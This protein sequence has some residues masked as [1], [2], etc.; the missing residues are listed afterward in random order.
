MLQSHSSIPTCTDDDAV[1][2][3]D[4]DGFDM[5]F[6]RGDLGKASEESCSV[7]DSS[8][9]AA[10]DTDMRRGTACIPNVAMKW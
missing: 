6:T 5:D 3:V 7:E 2:Q 4:G 10:I 9:V 1:E 8:M